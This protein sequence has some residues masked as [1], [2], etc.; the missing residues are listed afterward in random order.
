MAP[1]QDQIPQSPGRRSRDSV[2]VEHPEPGHGVEDLARQLYLDS[3]S[4]EGSTS[5][6]SDSTPLPR[7]TAV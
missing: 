7:S 6:T 5:H 3:L 1:D 2:A 4:V